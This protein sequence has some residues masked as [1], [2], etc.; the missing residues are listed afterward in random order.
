MSSWR[1]TKDGRH[2]QNRSKPGISSDNDNNTSLY[3]GSQPSSITPPKKVDIDKAAQAEFE[4]KHA[5]LKKNMTRYFKNRLTENPNQGM[6]E[7]YTKFMENTKPSGE[8][9]EDVMVQKIYDRATKAIQ[10][11]KSDKEE[12]YQLAVEAGRP[13]RDYTVK[14]IDAINECGNELCWVGFNKVMAANP[15]PANMTEE[16]YEGVMITLKKKA[17]SKIAEILTETRKTTAPAPAPTYTAPTYTAPKKWEASPN[18]PASDKQRS[19]MR[20]LTHRLEKVTMFDS[21][22][23]SPQK[24]AA[25]YMEL[26]GKENL[27]SREASDAISD[28]FGLIDDEM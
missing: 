23:G 4:K 12:K 10:K 9:Q 16:D 8:P 5:I 11:A 1:S 26:E 19:L 17:R 7:L 15:K 3:S 20:S 24:V 2:F 22:T 25:E 27:S 14:L 18:K 13:R 6:G 21:Y 28:M